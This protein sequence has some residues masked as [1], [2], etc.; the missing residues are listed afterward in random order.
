MSHWVL[1]KNV[2]SA[3]VERSVLYV[4]DDKIPQTHVTE[5][6]Y[7]FVDFLFVLSIIGNILKYSKI[8]VIL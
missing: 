4:N 7:I 5:V 2:E 1:E 8:I 3:I 6:F